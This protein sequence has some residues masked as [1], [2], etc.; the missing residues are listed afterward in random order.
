MTPNAHTLPPSSMRHP[1]SAALGALLTLV[2]AAACVDVAD[3]LP[4]VASVATTLN[5]SSLRTGDTLV[6]TVIGTND[7][8]RALE[9]PNYPCLARLE[10]RNEQD[11]PVEFGDPRFCTK[12]LFAPKVLAPHET[13]GDTVMITHPPVGQFRISGGL[14]LTLGEGSFVYGVTASVTVRP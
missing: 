8:S 3:T 14:P 1:R 10:I 11:Q 13:W 5:R 4:S 9:V 7:S 2:T 6:I 12:P